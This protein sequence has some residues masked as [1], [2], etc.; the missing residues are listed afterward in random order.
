MVLVNG[1][2]NAM[3][4]ADPIVTID[5][6]GRV[7]IPKAVRD[8]LCLTEGTTLK[9]SLS[10]DALTLVPQQAS[11]E[12]RKKNGFLIYD[13]ELLAKKEDPL[14]RTRMERGR[15]LLSRIGV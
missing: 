1:I 14:E 10:Q 9:V 11:T 13:G 6:A 12:L 8:R 15:D 4:Q 3:E 2:I 5:R 7:I